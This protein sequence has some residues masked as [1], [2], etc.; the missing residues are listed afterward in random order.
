MT[1]DPPAHAQ[2]TIELPPPA[3]DTGWPTKFE[4]HVLHAPGKPED[5]YSDEKERLGAVVG[6]LQIRV[7]RQR[8]Q[9]VVCAPT[10]ASERALELF[11]QEVSRAVCVRWAVRRRFG[12]RVVTGGWRPPARCA[13]ATA[14]LPPP[15]CRAQLGC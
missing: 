1:I 10:P 13:S 7:Q 11:C 9:S 8:V 5:V 3:E 15:C 14:L 2:T 4:W 12:R 6:E